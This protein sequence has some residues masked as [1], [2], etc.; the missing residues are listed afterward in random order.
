[1]NL[2]TDSG[3]V[4]FLVTKMYE[5]IISGGMDLNS[6]VITAG[7]VSGIV[8]DLPR[9]VSDNAIQFVWDR[10]NAVVR[11]SG[12]PASFPI[13]RLLA[14]ISLTYYNANTNVLETFL[15]LVDEAGN[16]VFSGLN[17]FYMQA[18]GA[19]TL[20]TGCVDLCDIDI[21][22]SSGQLIPF[23][24]NAASVDV[25]ASDAAT[26]V[27]QWQSIKFRVAVPLS[28]LTTVTAA[29]SAGTTDGIS[30]DSTAKL[31]YL[32]N[33]LAP[34][35]TAAAATANITT[36]G[37]G[38]VIANTASDILGT[39]VNTKQYVM[40]ISGK[41][42]TQQLTGGAPA[43]YLITATAT[44]TATATAQAISRG[45]GF[46][47][48]AANFPTVDYNVTFSIPTAADLVAAG[49]IAAIATPVTTTELALAVAGANLT[50]GGATVS[51]GTPASD[52]STYLIA[53]KALYSSA[54]VV[55]NQLAAGG[56]LTT[57]AA[58]EFSGAGTAVALTPPQYIGSSAERA[59]LQ[60]RAL[61]KDV[62]PDAMIS[63][64]GLI[65]AATVGTVYY[66]GF[67]A[68]T[69]VYEA[70]I[71]AR[72]L[73]AFPGA[74]VRTL[75]TF[76]N[77]ATPVSTNF[78]QPHYDT[79]TQTQYAATSAFFGFFD[80]LYTLGF[81]AEDV[82]PVLVAFPVTFTRQIAQDFDYW[83]NDEPKTSAKYIPSAGKGYILNQPLIHRLAGFKKGF[84]L[85]PT[86]VFLKG[87]DKASD[88]YDLI[89][90]NSKTTTSLFVKINPLA[91]TATNL[92]ATPPSAKV[93]Y[94][95]A[96]AQFVQNTL[97]ASLTL[98]SVTIG[99]TAAIVADTDVL[100]VTN[101]GGATLDIT[102][103]GTAAP[104]VFPVVA[105]TD[106]GTGISSTALANTAPGVTEGNPTNVTYS[107]VYTK[108]N[109]ANTLGVPDLS[110]E[111]L[112]EQCN[113][114]ETADMSQ[115]MA[116]VYALSNTTSAA[117]AGA[118]PN[119]LLPWLAAGSDLATVPTSTS[120]WFRQTYLTQLYQ[121]VA[122]YNNVD[123]EEIIIAA[124][125]VTP[126]L[127]QVE[128]SKLFVRLV[129]TPVVNANK[130]INIANLLTLRKGPWSLQK[131]P[132][133]ALV[134]I[135]KE[136]FDGVTTVPITKSIHYYV[137][138]LLDY[139]LVNF[140]DVSEAI[141][142]LTT[143][144][145]KFIEYLIFAA[146]NDVDRSNI[147]LLMGT[148]PVEQLVVLESI[149]GA[150][151]ATR[152]SSFVYYLKSF[153]M[154]DLIGNLTPPAPQANGAFVN[155]GTVFC[156]AAWVCAFNNLDGVKLLAP[157]VAPEILLSYVRKLTIYNSQGISTD[158]NASRRLVFDSN[159]VISTYQVS[160]A[161][162]S[163]LLV[164][165]GIIVQL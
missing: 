59:F 86:N 159:H 75:L 4:S 72:L 53:I 27:K 9:D 96:V 100:T 7:I 158:T 116:A 12:N 99:G 65:S 52:A 132:V 150:V 98:S 134:H 152:L 29:N 108:F 109:A 49:N 90:N 135:I 46:I 111:A 92:Q 129:E 147:L 37:S 63:S 77:S 40:T 136:F 48:A 107:L 66:S 36:L 74:N 165:M 89:F 102:V 68:N 120:T 42:T 125:N 81:K 149:L 31:T 155:D 71:N 1:M 151:R 56:Q 44:T 138:A 91:L 106:V 117:T 5:I 2:S 146:R 131:S 33:A 15:Q 70:Y 79:L 95:A 69:Y 76:Y 57:P 47:L 105:I 162:L 163:N 58:P 145:A 14:A 51:L 87:T 26:L 144:T 62:S 115:V 164:E 3:A 154:V 127:T 16:S 38:L 130:G 161:V 121:A 22:Q 157:Y 119:L 139:A 80:M 128:V 64:P 6:G 35:T 32:N 85:T 61:W 104:A 78:F 153:Q 8:G 133:H 11:A 17:D 24:V 160:N 110:Y 83:F 97:G 94:A 73:A 23:G 156:N 84:Q 114:L 148:T 103:A 123:V 140:S 82:F 20:A 122:N 21:W 41:T 101:G 54:N 45:S 142:A 39:F 137:G 43:K 124:A 10:R 118:G 67:V 18:G 93:L 30:Y 88:I 126:A 143:T 112:F 19:G 25:L 60:L 113:N 34:V 55:A 28:A 13:A 50:T 141:N